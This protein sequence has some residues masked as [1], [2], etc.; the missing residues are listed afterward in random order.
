MKNIK[1]P[2]EIQIYLIS[3]SIATTLFGKIYKIKI[4]TKKKIPLVF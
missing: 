3:K 2:D 1:F 4:G